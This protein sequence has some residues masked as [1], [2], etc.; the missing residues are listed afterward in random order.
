MK[1]P[2]KSHENI[3]LILLMR[4]LDPPLLCYVQV[5]CKTEGGLRR[6]YSSNSI[7]CLILSL[8]NAFTAMHVSHFILE[9]ANSYFG[10][11]FYLEEY[12]A[13]KN[14]RKLITASNDHF[15]FSLQELR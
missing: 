4:H 9:F 10:L 5:Q 8:N 15:I 3:I 14:S 7:K 13:R 12:M 1:T 2:P 6:T 11:T